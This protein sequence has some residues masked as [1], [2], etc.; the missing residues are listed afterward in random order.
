MSYAFNNQISKI[1]ETKAN[2]TVK[3]HSVYSYSWSFQYLLIKTS[4]NKYRAVNNAI[5]NLS[6]TVNQLDLIDI[7]N[8]SSNLKHIPFE[9]NKI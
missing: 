2:R 6:S 4:Q 7:Y 9:W 8:H 1:C 5:D 3:K